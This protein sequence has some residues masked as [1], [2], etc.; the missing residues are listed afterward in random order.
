MAWDPAQYLKFAD[1]RLRPAI[2]IYS[3]A[4]LHWAGDHERLFTSFLSSLK[5][6][7]ALAVQIPQNFSAPS[8]PAMAEAALSGPWRKRLEPLLKPIPVAEP[9]FYYGVL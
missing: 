8:H 6:G 7:G 4:A 3:N 5:P 1:Q 9:A 2:V